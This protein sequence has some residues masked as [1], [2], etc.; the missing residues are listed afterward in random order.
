MKTR[1]LP[2]L[3]LFT[4]LT[5]FFSSPPSAKGQKM[6]EHCGM[7]EVH[8]ALEAIEYAVQRWNPFLGE[9][10][11]SGLGAFFGCQYR[12]FLKKNPLSGQNW[13]FCE[14]DVFLGGAATVYS[15]EAFPV[16]DQ[17]FEPCENGECPPGENCANEPVTA[18]A[19][20]DRI[21]D[22]ISFGRRGGQLVEQEIERTP[23]KFLNDPIDGGIAWYQ[24]GIIKKVPPGI[25]RSRLKFFND[26]EYGGQISVDIEVVSHK[27][28]LTRLANGTWK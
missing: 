11:N 28:H 15:Y 9:F 4:I 23:I 8:S 21:N 6:N 5:L 18:S 25:Y 1:V 13:M 17:S 10:G 7:G 12:L 26:D 22:T 20:L 3:I 2:I 19:L 24:I 27:E 14:E 16:C